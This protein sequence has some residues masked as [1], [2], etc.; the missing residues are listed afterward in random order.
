MGERRLVSAT[1]GSTA[2][3]GHE[4]ASREGSPDMKKIETTLLVTACSAAMTLLQGC[5]STMTDV[6]AKDV[7]AFRRIE[8]SHGEIPA[9][10]IRNAKAVAIFASTQ[11][12][13]VFGGKGGSG[14]FLKRIGDG[15][16]PPLAIDLVEGTV[17]LQLGAQDED[18]VYIFKTDE[19][20]S[21]FLHTGRYAIA[22]AQGS[23]GEHSGRTDHADISSDD[24][25]LYV[26]S[27]GVYGGLLLGGTGFSI[28]EDLNRETYGDHVTTEMIVN[29]KVD[30]PPGT[31]VLWKLLKTEGQAGGGDRADATD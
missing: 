2:I 11:A 28:D 30:P 7:N 19:A 25:S 22:H 27:S 20:V 10:T 21:H 12:G 14:V 3:E 29:G 23:F 24:I 1:E 15:F 5:A 18:A 16:S 6:I 4:E 8:S 17:G 26:R 13:L 31:L 9:E